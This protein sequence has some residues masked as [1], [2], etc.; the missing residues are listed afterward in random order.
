MLVEQNAKKSLSVCDYGFV[1]ENGNIVCSGTGD[2][3]LNNPEIA[4][5][6][7]GASRDIS[8]C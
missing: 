5:A 3:L 7:L 2:E 6:Y 1:I 4:K 8:N